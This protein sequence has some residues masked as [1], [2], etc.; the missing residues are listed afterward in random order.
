MRPGAAPVVASGGSGQRGRPQLIA[1]VQV[2]AHWP[3]EVLARVDTH[4]HAAGGREL[5]T[6]VTSLPGGRDWLSLLDGEQLVDVSPFWVS[7]PVLVMYTSRRRHGVP[8][9][10]PPSVPA[11]GC[12]SPAAKVADHGLRGG[13]SG[14]ARL[15][16][17]YLRPRPGQVAA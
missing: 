2:A 8:R 15:D 7:A 11:R 16:R 12:G 6:Y 13:D 1:A 5:I 4:G 17:P 10:R 9:H 3:D 14:E